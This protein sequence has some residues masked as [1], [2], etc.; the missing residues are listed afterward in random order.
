MSVPLARYKVR[1]DKERELRVALAEM[2]R[3]VDNYKDACDKGEIGPVIPFTT[4]V[5]LIRVT[6]RE[7]AGQLPLNDET[8][9]VI[10]KKLEAQLFEREYRRPGRPVILT[11]LMDDW[12]ARRWTLASLRSR[13]GERRVTAVRTEGGRVV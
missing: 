12:P 6:T 9:K 1:R 2:R 4:G 8:Q 5:H 3:A 7:N 11:G 10:R 13:Y